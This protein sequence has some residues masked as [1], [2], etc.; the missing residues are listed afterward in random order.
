MIQRA[1]ITL[2]ALVLAPSAVSCAAEPL[3]VR[4]QPFAAVVAQH[5]LAEGSTGKAPPDEPVQAPTS[6]HQGDPPDPPPLTA[7]VQHE[8]TLHYHNGDIEIQGVKTLELE[9]ARVTP[10]RM[11]RFAIELWIGREL[12]ER[13]RFDFPLLAAS[14]APDAEKAGDV[15]L[16]ARADVTYVVSVPDSTRATRA[17]LVDRATGEVVVLPW[18]PQSTGG[19]LPSSAEDAK[20]APLGP[21]RPAP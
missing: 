17:H 8:F 5:H 12:V 14:P 10:R 21:S 19:P 13:V 16:A 2:G 18:P 4:S 3:E 7:R 11:G 1:S 6:V 9:R 20:T 15:S